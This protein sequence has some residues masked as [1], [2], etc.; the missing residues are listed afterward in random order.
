MNPTASFPFAGLAS[1]AEQPARSALP[2]ID[3]RL[4]RRNRFLTCA[5]LVHL[6]ACHWPD[7][8]ER[9]EVVG[10]WVWVEFQEPPAPEVRRQLAEFGF[11]W[12]RHRQLWQHPGGDQSRRGSGG[13]PRRRYLTHFPADL[14]PV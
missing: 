11:H 2:P 4:R 5:R 7:L 10:R 13:D 12:N 14:W 6:L 8:Y 9:A 1:R 3:F